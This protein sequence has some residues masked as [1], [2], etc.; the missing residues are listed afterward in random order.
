MRDKFGRRKRIKLTDGELALGSW[1]YITYKVIIDETWDEIYEGKDEYLSEHDFPC[2]LWKNGCRLC[3]KHINYGK[4][5]CGRC[6][7]KRTQKSKGVNSISWCGCD[8][9]SWYGK[10]C[11]KGKGTHSERISSAINICNVL[12]KELKKERKNEVVRN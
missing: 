5:T 4:A 8:T 7:L 6:P 3:E 9:N 2:Y 11:Y 12:A 1:L 10:V